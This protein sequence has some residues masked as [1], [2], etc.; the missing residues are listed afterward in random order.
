M[1]TP[2]Q[3]IDMAAALQNDA[4][5]TVYTDEACLPYLNMALDELQEV[6]EENNIPLTNEVSSILSITAGTTIIAFT[7][8][9]PTLP[10][11]LIEIQQLWE[12]P[13]GSSDPFIPMQRME[14]VPLYMNGQTYSNFMLWAWVDNEIHL[15]TVNRDIDLKLDFIKSVFPTPLQMSDVDVEMGLKFKNIKTYLGY[16]T[17]SLCSMYIGVNETRAMTL[18]SQAETALERALNIPTKG[19]QA[20]ATR[21]RPFR[22]SYK[23]RT[24]I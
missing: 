10:S 20:I 12:K 21:R 17:A 1:P 14:F 16:K 9:T 22:A 11:N 15:P 8:T 2:A 23:S 6:M 13:A 19:K 24:F 5:Q 7:G 18:N 3:I 4:A